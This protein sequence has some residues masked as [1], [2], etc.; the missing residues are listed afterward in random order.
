MFA[1]FSLLMKKQQQTNKQRMKN[2]LWTGKLMLKHVIKGEYSMTIH[3]RTSPMTRVRDGRTAK[4]RVHHEL[5]RWKSPRIFL[6]CNSTMHSKLLTFF[7]RENLSFF[8]FCTVKYLVHW[9]DHDDT[10]VRG[11]LELTMR[12]D[13]GQ[14]QMSTFLYEEHGHLVDDHEHLRTA[15]EHF[16]S[17]TWAKRCINRTRKQGSFFGTQSFSG[18]PPTSIRESNPLIDAVDCRHAS[19]PGAFYLCMSILP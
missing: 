6:L 13:H 18:T 7:S 1:D 8:R 12:F 10:Q 2:D 14:F 3:S 19:C 5:S 15:H 9:T 17:E 16:I 4:R 11:H